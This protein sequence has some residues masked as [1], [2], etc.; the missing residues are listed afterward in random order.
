[1]SMYVYKDPELDHIYILYIYATKKSC[2]YNIFMMH[3]CLKE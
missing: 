1:M 3:H 2:G